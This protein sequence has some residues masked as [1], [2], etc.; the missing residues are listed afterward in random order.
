M[1]IARS[2]S[3]HHID[4]IDHNRCMNPCSWCI[5][6][7]Y[8]I[9]EAYMARLNDAWIHIWKLRN[10]MCSDEEQSCPFMYLLFV[11]LH[12]YLVSYSVIQ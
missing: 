1:V 8:H 7:G 4:H 12:T 6:F 3:D 11:H 2:L 5:T 9:I 10:R